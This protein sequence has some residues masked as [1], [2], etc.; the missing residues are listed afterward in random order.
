MEDGAGAAQSI[1]VFVDNL[2]KDV[3]VD[4]FRQIFSSHGQVRDAFIPFKRS[5]RYNTKF[6][7][8]RYQ[9]MEEAS[10]AI[11]ALNGV[12]IRNFSIQVN[13]ARYGKAGRNN[14]EAGTQ[15]AGRTRR[16]L[17]KS[18]ISPDPAMQTEA[19]PIVN[20]LQLK[21]DLNSM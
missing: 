21:E 11:H 9:T 13:L 8:I 3:D 16:P 6:G 1:T 18:G 7:F 2:P 20:Q 12:I 5:S 15:A 19:L 10:R 17:N 4:W 14:F